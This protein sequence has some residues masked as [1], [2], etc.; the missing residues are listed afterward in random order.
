M[1]NIITH[2]IVC[3]PATISVNRNNTHP[4]KRLYQTYHDGSTLTSGGL[5][6]TE[7]QA[8]LGINGV[9]L[10]L[11]IAIWIPIM[12]RKWEF[13]NIENRSARYRQRLYMVLC[14]SLVC[15]FGTFLSMGLIAIIVSSGINV[16]KWIAAILLLMIYSSL[17][18]VDIKTKWR[19]FRKRK[20][21]KLEMQ[22]TQKEKE[23]AA[24]QQVF[25]R[26]AEQHPEIRELDYIT[27][28]IE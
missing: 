20:T 15:T 7:R 3:A 21:H 8:S 16:L 17:W 27:S 24:T 13:Q 9:F 5:Y 1:S 23:L 25:H 28:A 10:T 19:A 14:G 22:L 4:Y 6:C 18:D 2:T 12:S 11:L 26:L